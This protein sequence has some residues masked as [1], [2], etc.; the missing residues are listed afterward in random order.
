[1]EKTL[2]ILMLVMILVSLFSAL[3][4]LFRSRGND[5]RVVKALTLRISLSLILFLMLMAGYYFGLIS[6]RGL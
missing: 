6:G 5:S 1:M 2:V 4:Y 3:G